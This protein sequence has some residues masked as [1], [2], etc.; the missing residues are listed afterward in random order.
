MGLRV[1]IVDDAPFLH[2][3]L[4][5]LL[6]AAG[7]LVVAQAYD[8]EEAVQKVLFEKPD[9]V[10]MD[11]VM[12][13]MNGF[14]ASE[15]I[16]K[17]LPDMKIIACSTLTDAD[18]IHQSV[19]VGCSNFIAKPFSGQDLVE[20]IKETAESESSLLLDSLDPFAEELKAQ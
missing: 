7:M 16:L 6:S 13:K 4:K 9:I 20:M 2:D 17:K 12:P 5:P 15:E 3:V 10:L 1:V 18:I 14:Q 11:I 19:Q 8:G